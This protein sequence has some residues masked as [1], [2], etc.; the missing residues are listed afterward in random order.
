[1]SQPSPS[2]SRHIGSS[3]H[4]SPFCSLDACKATASLS[5][6]SWSGVILDSW[7]DMCSSHD[8]M[9]FL[10]APRDELTPTC[11]KAT[12]SNP[13]PLCSAAADVLDAGGHMPQVAGQKIFAVASATTVAAPR[14]LEG[15]TSPPPLQAASRV[16]FPDSIA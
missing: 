12:S 5:T 6:T 13:S 1:M 2:A 14:S 16:A 10:A 15:G 11:R 7:S 9:D 3:A 4:A 8:L